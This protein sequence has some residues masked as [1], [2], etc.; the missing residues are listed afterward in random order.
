MAGGGESDLLAVSDLHTK[1]G[2]QLR[3]DIRQDMRQW[4]RA[5]YGVA[6]G[7]AEM[8]QLLPEDFCGF[9]SSPLSVMSRSE[10]SSE[11]SDMISQAEHE[12]IVK[13]I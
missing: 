2:N 6:N 9:R 7:S 1:L 3:A 5:M 13:T 11:I 10:D 12:A 4:L 8:S